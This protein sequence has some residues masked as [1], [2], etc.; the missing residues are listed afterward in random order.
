MSIYKRKTVV[1]AVQFSEDEYHMDGLKFL[2]VWDRA[3]FSELWFSKTAKDGRYY[4]TVQPNTLGT[5]ENITVNDG[6]YIIREEMGCVHTLP[7]EIFEKNYELS[8]DDL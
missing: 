4:I 6:D 8:N 3:M 7:K 1:H 5:A 2:D